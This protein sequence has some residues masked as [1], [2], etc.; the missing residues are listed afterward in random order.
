MKTA[1]GIAT[2][3]LGVYLLGAALTGNGPKLW[4]LVKKEGGFI[5]WGLAGAGV[6]YISTR[7]EL[8]E[9]GPALAA[10]AALGVAMKVANDPTIVNGIKSAWNMLPNS[11]PAKRGATGSF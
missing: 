9:I 5:K 8:G 3:A 7:P 4:Q 1:N 6:W 2:L 11:T 10:V